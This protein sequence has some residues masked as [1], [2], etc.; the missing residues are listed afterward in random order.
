M[1]KTSL[2]IK[3]LVS[4]MNRVREQM[5]A[6]IPPEHAD[7]F[8]ALVMDGVRTVEEICRRNHITPNDLPAPSRRAYA[9]LRS[10]DLKHLP[11]PAPQASTGDG[12]AASKT[13][14][15]T[16][17]VATCNDY[18]K[19]FARLATT[20]D[21]P[22]WSVEHPEVQR[23]AAE[24][25]AEA[26]GIAA[27]CREEG[28]TPADMPTQS[29]HGYQWLAFLGDPANLALHL[30]TLTEG[31]QI[32]Q[33]DAAQKALSP[34]QRQL[35]LHIEF[36]TIGHIYRSHIAAD[37]ITITASEG[38]IGA[39]H[40]VLKALVYTTL[41]HP[42]K[43]LAEQAKIYSRS[44]TFEEILLTLELTTADLA[45]NTKGQH[46]DLATIF[47]QVNTAYFGGTLSRPRLTWNKTLTAR[48]L[49]H[50]QFN[51][52]T[53]MLS[54]S[55]DDAAVPPYVVEFVMYHELL[56]KSLGIKLVNGRRYA[57]TSEFREAEQRFAQYEQAKTFL[58]KKLQH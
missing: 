53:V 3:G 23:L 40:P 13:I 48:K 2:R 12:R 49:G 21:T 4:L 38:F 33:T 46:Y 22:V 5:S 56:H 20:Q 11:L 9:Y 6:G 28:G 18:H 54:L 37:G 57:H 1:K 17:I 30:T 52:D 43:K 31:Y 36:Y 26:E 50:Y 42:E 39:P 15:I 24:L 44:E 25:R 16:N 47:E 8:R 51:T 41:R 7:E 29:R 35:P 19:V 14:R 58:A 45:L 34:A 10:L 27:L 55:L 32:A